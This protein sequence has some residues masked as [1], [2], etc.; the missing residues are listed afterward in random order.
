MS[1]ESVIQC[2]HCKAAVG[3]ADAFCPKCGTRVEQAPTP[4]VVATIAPAAAVETAAAPMSQPPTPVLAAPA[5][6]LV[7]SPRSKTVAVVLAVVVASFTWLYT[8][9]LD[10]KKFW[11]GMALS[12][13]GA[14][15]SAV[16][17]GLLFI[18]GVWLW[19]V[20]DRVRQPESWYRS[21]QAA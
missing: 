11:I 9:R 17:I 21:Y 8:Y 1:T 18:F 10:K 19:A 12:V 5:T 14:I 16:G 2:P 4:Q 3:A 7:A 6:P 13:L 15:L 20:V